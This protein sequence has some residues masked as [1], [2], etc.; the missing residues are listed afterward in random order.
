[1]ASGL[2]HI[3]L[4]KKLQ[5][6]LPETRLKNIF[7]AGSDFLLVGAVGPDLPYAS[8]ADHYF[9]SDESELADKFHYKKTNQI[10]LRALQE[11][12]SRNGNMEEMAHFYMFSFFMG[13]ISHVVADGIIHPFVR[14]KVGNYAENK[15]EH[16]CLEMQLDVLFM[17]DFTKE[18]GYTLELNYT[19][20]HDELS[21]IKDYKESAVI[22]TLFS[23]LIEQVYHER[24]SS[25]T[26]LEWI[27]G[28]HRLFEVAE[29]EHPKFY[30]VLEANTF[31]FKNRADINRDRAILLGKP[32]DRDSN[33]LNVDQISFF[34]HCVPRYFQTFIP[35]AQKA[36][37]YVYEDGPELTEEDIPSINLDT[38]R[39]LAHDDLNVT[40][41][42]WQNN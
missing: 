11:L 33:F 32:K 13:Y 8:V 20:L 12:K 19:N 15:A 34:D 3:L 36:Y 29:G 5:D 39:L 28:L 2:T 23:E 22:V 21:N 18:T 42:F 35:L 24:H 16:R 40:P 38:G 10:P 26:I 7:A 6:N 30:R 25:K 27:N 1:M 4:T 31:F 9:F 37:A 14:D 17:E 41:R